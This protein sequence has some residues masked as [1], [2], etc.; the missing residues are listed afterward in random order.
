MECP[1]HG[2]PP[3][4]AV[5]TAWIGSGQNGKE[6]EEMTA[7]ESSASGVGSRWWWFF[8]Y[9]V[10]LGVLGLVALGNVMDATLVTT[11]FVGWLLLFGG[12]MPP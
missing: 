6:H 12:F 2:N 5:V 11:V 10:A 8:I 9:G 1:T 3:H 7:V 4:A